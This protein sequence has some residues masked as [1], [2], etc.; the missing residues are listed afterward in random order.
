MKQYLSA[1]NLAKYYGDTLVFENTSFSVH[2]GQRIALVGPN[3]TGKTTLLRII[4]GIDIAD[5]GE[6]N[7]ASNTTIGYADQH[8]TFSE[9]ETIYNVMLK[10]IADDLA[11]FE[12]IK[13]L[14]LAFSTTDYESEAFQKIS[15]QYEALQQEVQE[16]GLYQKETKIKM[17]LTKLGF[18]ESD[19]QKKT[20]AL[21]GGQQIRLHLAKTLLQEPELL[22]L[23]EP[24]NHLD[25]E[26]I[27]WLNNYL[28]N[29]PY[30]I[31]LITHDEKLISTL[32][33]N[34]WQIINQEL[35]AYNGT[36]Q[37][38]KKQ[39][40]EQTKFLVAQK[41]KLDK[42]K[43][44]L[45][46]FIEKN[47]TRKSTTKRAQ[48]AR[49]R[50]HK[51]QD[52]QPIKIR[53]S[54]KP[55][56]LP[57][58]RQ[59]GKFVFK[60]HDVSIGYTTPLYEPFSTE[61][62]RY[63]R[64]A[65]VGKNGI[66]KSTLLSTLANKLQPLSGDIV[67]G[68]HVDIAY[69]QQQQVFAH[70]NQSVY[71]TFADVYPDANREIIHPVLARFGFPQEDV[72]LINSRLSG[73]E[74]QRLLLALLYYQKANTLL[75]DEPT[76]HLDITSKQ[77]LIQSF[78][79]FDGTIIFAS[80]DREFIEQLA[81]K[82]YFFHEGKIHF[83]ATYADFEAF[84]LNLDTTFSYSPEKSTTQ[85]AALDRM[86]QKRIQ[87]KIRSL[88]KEIEQIEEQIEIVEMN[89]QTAG[90]ALLQEENYSD[91]QKANELQ[92]QQQRDEQR[93]E[94]LLAKWEQ[95]HEQLQ[96]VETNLS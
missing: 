89:I 41:E 2:Q 35:Y 64:I 36:Y 7:C 55:F 12:Q 76:N 57:V 26:T 28:L 29:Y 86:E 22:L 49:K 84:S 78:K 38:F 43:Q 45:E 83:F 71:S 13:T 18:A 14:E 81:T 50:L 6:I 9:N 72:H 58:Q 52:V 77:A 37:N 3:G 73:G 5:E 91:Y 65:L 79:A 32:G 94:S 59:S 74:K 66:G 67:R 20:L 8:A 27:M 92:Q 42:E 34:I 48:S 16:K 93:L 11:I 39:I 96:E 15:K 85:T 10:E 80:H 69:F 75:L 30:A 53:D 87:T 31:I 63:E 19:W 17:L 88:K 90:L 24:T 1:T 82:I 47:I 60:L 46:V 40:A 44:K 23:D 56:T 95:L 25:I 54:L 21:S 62:L 61:F 33:T 51:M 4:A 68:H 70:E